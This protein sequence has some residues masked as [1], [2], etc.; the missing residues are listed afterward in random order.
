LGQMA[1]GIAHDINNAILPAALYTE[2]LLEQETS[3]SPPA[4]ENLR[5]VSRAIEDV[6]ATVGR[7]RE[8]FRQRPPQVPLAPVPVN[9]SIQAVIDLT[10]ARWSDTPQQRGVV[11]KVATDLSPDDPVILGVEGEVR[12]ALTNVFFNAFDAMPEGG[13]MTVRTGTRP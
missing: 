4:R 1:M 10:R 6:A 9:R 8:F 3:L 11:I 7:M 5:I 12:E 2:S 13:T